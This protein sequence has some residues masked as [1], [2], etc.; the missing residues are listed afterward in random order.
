MSPPFTAAVIGC[1]RM[2]AFTS[3]SVLEYG[4][5]CFL[6]SAHAE[7][8]EL[9]EGVHLESVCDP[10]EDARLKAAQR[11]EAHGVFA[12]YQAL[13]AKG[14]PDIATLATRTIGRAQM[15]RDFVQAGT[16]ALHVEKPMCNSV[17]ELT[18]LEDVLAADTVFMT[19]GAVRRHFAI[20]QEAVRRARSGVYGN[21]L[22]AYGEFGARTLYWSHPHTVDLLLMAAQGARV[23]AV[24]AR[25]GPVEREGMTITNDPVVLDAGV[26][27]ESGFSGHLTQM[28]GTDL[29]LACQT[30]QIA[31][32][33][34][35][36]S[37]WL[38][39]REKPAPDA[40][41]SGPA[42]ANP[43]HE[44]ERIEFAAPQGMA[45]GAL[46]PILQLRDCLRGDAE[47]IKANATIKR[48]IITG[49]RILFAIVQS[50]L[51]GG[52]PVQLDE[53]DPDLVIEG[54]TNGTPA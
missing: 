21:L 31:V 54:R 24:Q 51:E 32:V 41:A 4:P 18:M 28:P 10:S 53:V 47:A 40:P 25:L 42:G 15:I 29:R 44:P 27:F 11:Y 30:A 38:S 16:R 6:P 13:L 34:N 8:I 46:A 37:L 50:H 19:L 9:A 33:A 5:E 26:W 17:N 14:A 2:G 35:G 20:Y 22:A 1:G 39:G 45:Q 49:Q 48:D 52:R 43:Y 7:A 3:P 23:E 12:D 36:S